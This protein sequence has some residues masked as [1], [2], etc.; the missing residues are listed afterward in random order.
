MKRLYLEYVINKNRPG[1]LGDIASI[2]GLLKINILNIT[3]IDEEKRGFL[4]SLP[5]NLT[6]GYLAS[7]LHGIEDLT[8][9]YLREPHLLDY[10]ALKHGERIE[11]NQECPPMYSFQRQ[12][13]NILVDFLGSLLTQEEKIIIGLKG[14]P[15]IGK[16]EAA[17]ASCV[18]ANRRWILISSTLLHK[19]TRTSLPQSDQRIQR[20]LLF[21]ALTT[22]DRSSR[23]H[24]QFALQLLQQDD[25]KII[26][27]PE[28][29]IHEG[30]LRKED[31]HIFIE[32]YKGKKK[33]T[34]KRR[35]GFT[36]FDIS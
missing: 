1:L 34:E 2:L 28:I 18:H 5:P 10:L 14:R 13:L 19:T 29:F 32:L 11:E 26:E 9:R 24:R 16:T 7:F 23:E 20:V 17:I 12:Q 27:H 4:L 30:I 35:W 15:R 21:D 25:Q 3:S 31:F 36:S 33:E 22:M 8:I 6:Q